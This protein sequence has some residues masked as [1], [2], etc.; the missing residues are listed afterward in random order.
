MVQD[1]LRE[2]AGAAAEI[3][4]E[5]ALRRAKPG[6]EFLA[7]RAAPRAH[8][9]LVVVGG[10]EGDFGFG[11]LDSLLAK[12]RDDSLAVL[13]LSPCGRGHRRTLNVLG[14]VRGCDPSPD[15]LCRE[16]E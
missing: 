11:H 2:R 10:V 15:L 6:E 16:S 9:A 5:R 4:P 1:Q 13:P 12:K 3:E 7:D 8:E 14:S